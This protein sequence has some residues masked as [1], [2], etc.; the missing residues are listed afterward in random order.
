MKRP[1]L[2]QYLR[3]YN[4]MQEN[5]I[6]CYRPSEKHG[7]NDRTLYLSDEYDEYKAYNHRS[8]LENEVV[9]EFDNEDV[10]INKELILKVEKSIKDEGVQYSLWH[11]GN[12]SYHLH[13]FI[14]PGKCKNI[15]LLKK[16][17]MRHYTEDCSELPDLRLSGNHLVRAE[18]GVHEK[19]GRT[20]HRL[21]ETPH[22]PQPKYISKLLWKKYIAEQQRIVKARM[23]MNLNELDTHPSVKF[24]LDTAQFKECEDGR[25]R[26]LFIL[27]QVLRH[28]YEKDNLI[29][30]LQEWYRYSGGTKFSDFDIERKVKYHIVRK[31]YVITP[32]Y[33]NELL[34]ELGIDP[35]TITNEVTS[36][37]SRAN[38]E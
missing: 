33:V 25:E 13:F 3:L 14:N 26:A 8:I 2:K 28:K 30:T 9:I 34:E 7:W 24:L 36:N 18:Y 20:K 31:P 6:V 37:E 15:S 27:I 10:A 38:G 1:S 19:S 17:L 22:Y 12:K 5:I 23:T 4:D 11:S 32:N 35:S 29:K 21:R 16:V